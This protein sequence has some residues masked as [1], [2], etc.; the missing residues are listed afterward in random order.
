MTRWW[1]GEGL[2]A[3]AET[4]CLSRETDSDSHGAAESLLPP[5]QPAAAAL[6]ASA[7]TGVPRLP[8][9][10]QRAWALALLALPGAGA[11]FCASDYTTLTVFQLR[12]FMKTP[13]EPIW[14]SAE[15]MVTENFQFLADPEPA[16]R[17]WFLH[18]ARVHESVGNGYMIYAGLENG[19]FSGYGLSGSQDCSKPGQP[20]CTVWYTQRKK[21]QARP[22]DY[23]D[24]WRSLA[25]RYGAV[26]PWQE[27][28][29]ATGRS[30]EPFGCRADPSLARSCSDPLKCR[31]FETGGTTCALKAACKTQHAADGTWETKAGAYLA[32]SCAS[33]GSAS[34]SIAFAQQT[35]GHSDCVDLTPGSDGHL[36]GCQDYDVRFYY[37]VG[38]SASDLQ[39]DQGLCEDSGASCSETLPSAFSLKGVGTVDA[40]ADTVTL[41]APDATVNQAGQILTLD[42][43]SGSSEG[44]IAAAAV[45]SIDD[46]A[47]NSVTLASV[48]ATIATGQVLQLADVAGQ[49]CNAAPKD[50][51]LVVASVDGAVITFATSLTAGDAAA[52]TDCVITRAAPF[53]LVVAAYSSPTITV[54]TEISTGATAAGTC[55]IS[56][57]QNELQCSAYAGRWTEPCVFSTSSLTSAEAGIA[58]IDDA[59]DTI[60]VAAAAASSFVAGQRLQLMDKPGQVCAAAPKGVDLVVKSVKGAD[61]QLSTDLTAGDQSASTHCV[62]TRVSSCA[63]AVPGR[64]LDAGAHM[65]RPYRWRSYDPRYRLWYRQAKERF[66]A[67]QGAIT[68]SWSDL[69]TFA[70]GQ[71]IGLTAIRTVSA[72]A[73]WCEGDFCS[74]CAAADVSPQ[75]IA[76]GG[77]DDT[78]N[79]I[80]LA[81]A[82]NTIVPGQTLRLSSASGV[83]CTATPLDS[84]LVVTSVSGAVITLSTSLTS[85]DTQAATNCQ[86]THNGGRCRATDARCTGGSLAKQAAN[87]QAD[88]ESL[89]GTW[90]EPCVYSSAGSGDCVGTPLLGV[91]AVDYSL[92]TLRNWLKSVIPDS[93]DI[94]V[95][96]VDKSAGS[97][98][99]AGTV[100]AAS[101]GSGVDPITHTSLLVRKSAEHINRA[102]G[103]YGNWPD[104]YS[105]VTVPNWLATAEGGENV[106]QINI[107]VMSIGDTRG[108]DW[109]VVVAAVQLRS[110]ERP[111]RAD[112]NHLSCEC[113]P[114]FRST[115]P[116]DRLR[117]KEYEDMDCVF[118]KSDRSI[119]C[120]EAEKVDQSCASSE[121][122][123]ESG[124]VNCHGGDRVTA[125]KGFFVKQDPGET[126]QVFRC[127]DHLC[128]G[129]DETDNTTDVAPRCPPNAEPMSNGNCCL[130]GHTGPLCG[131]CREGYAWSDDLVCVPCTS[132]SPTRLFM[133]VA[134]LFLF[135]TYS[136]LSKHFFIIKKASGKNGAAIKHTSCC[137]F[138]KSPWCFLIP[139]GTDL[140]TTG[141]SEMQTLTFWMQSFTLLEIDGNDSWWWIMTMVFHFKPS[142]GVKVCPYGLGPFSKWWVDVFGPTVFLLATGILTHSLVCVHMAYKNAALPCSRGVAKRLL[143]VRGLSDQFHT[144]EQVR[145]VFES[146][147]TEC[148]IVTQVTVRH[149]ISEQKNTSWALIKLSQAVD[150]EVIQAQLDLLK[151]R[152]D[153]RL[154]GTNLEVSAFSRAQAKV[155]TGGMRGVYYQTTFAAHFWNQ[156]HKLKAVFLDVAI[157][158]LMPIMTK[159]LLITHCRSD[160]PDGVAR[161]I[162]LPEIE[163]EGGMYQLTNVAAILLF[164]VFGF[165]FPLWLGWQLYL[166]VDAPTAE[167]EKHSIWIGD[168]HAAKTKG[169]DEW[170]GKHNLGLGQRV[171]A[172]L[173]NAAECVT[174]QD[175]DRDGDV[176]SDGS[177]H[178]VRRQWQRLFRQHISAKSAGHPSELELI[179]AFE[180][181]AGETA[182]NSSGVLDFKFEGHASKV[183]LG[184]VAKR[185]LN[186]GMSLAKGMMGVDHSD[187]DDESSFIN[188]GEQ[189]QSQGG[190]SKNVRKAKTLKPGHVKAWLE[191]LEDPPVDITKNRVAMR[192][193]E[194]EYET[195]VRWAYEDRIRMLFTAGLTEHDNYEQTI[196]RHTKHI[197]RLDGQDQADKGSSQ[198]RRQG[199]GRDDHLHGWHV[200]PTVFA[201]SRRV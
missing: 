192:K 20:A 53:P 7:P 28:A 148:G 193:S 191:S 2:R 141:G 118:C 128:L 110:C 31:A 119:C 52:S 16:M 155:S 113:K 132:P 158:S 179:Q 36:P 105:N 59:V 27:S 172:K 77:I 45:A 166:R 147:P 116:T 189:L 112:E 137:S 23:P 81:A 187:G 150:P 165:C 99:P 152:E 135:S 101:Q 85:G 156:Q 159:S 153:D 12:D 96:I 183:D 22:T 168:P 32:D 124:C 174:R 56:R 63:Q 48:D 58:S 181:K 64:N 3:G 61:I 104:S 127:L 190:D 11:Q 44:A 83:S 145:D 67:S 6:V 111:K 121:E 103:A 76:A 39:N 162:R 78:A 160:T 167:L 95:W 88:C 92:D 80:T 26:A 24:H 177:A 134:S 149:R 126:L 201:L 182:V 200:E 4:V 13:Y 196:E 86:V 195:L 176:G 120:A 10:M 90:V 136:V 72:D 102:F 125:R 49:V 198:R 171:W 129:L 50:A 98:T 130:N 54:S 82:D 60:T 68:E 15:A 37:R 38:C 154:V 163:C 169:T 84:D 46:A 100:L 199:E 139:L 107:E 180:Y 35:C 186:R 74:N 8:T 19:L 106:R 97:Q 123:L 173:I 5:F 144:E 170:G 43:A 161:V 184:H 33:A 55:V 175:I 108:L 40:S 157:Y 9:T 34:V 75:A 30:G 29:C 66:F 47:A 70:S 87:T 25:Q 79:T 17:D 143:H 188:H 114:N 14:Q 1:C 138:S 109:L 133:I 71:G 151:R 122:Q 41:S 117:A 115:L 178:K 197:G 185:K 18:Q 65:D 21:D 51:D 142:S 94:A 164:S 140:P 93:D 89:G 62:L 69:Y 91:L 131:L 146:L 57:A 194:E 73:S 42:H